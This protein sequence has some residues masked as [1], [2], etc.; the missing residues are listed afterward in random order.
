MW[1]LADSTDKASFRHWIEAVDVQLEH[2]HKWRHSDYVLNRVE[3]SAEPITAGVLARCI[4]E[5]S[6]DIERVADFEELG[7]EDKGPRDISADMSDRRRRA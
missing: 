6:L 4:V 2:V 1:R 3:R 7:V 5:A